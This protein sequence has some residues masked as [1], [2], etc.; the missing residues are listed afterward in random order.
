MAALAAMMGLVA[1]R[2]MATAVRIDDVLVGM[3]DSDVV[4]KDTNVDARRFGLKEWWTA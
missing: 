4:C 1:I 2:M 3:N